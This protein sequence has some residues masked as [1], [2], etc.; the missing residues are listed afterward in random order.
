MRVNN[1]TLPEEFVEC[2]NSGKLQRTRGSWKLRKERDGYSNHLE[3]ELA[4]IFATVEELNAHTS[5]LRDDFQPD[6]FYGA[7]EKASGAPGAIP[8]ILDFSKIVCFGISGDGAPF[9]FDFRDDAERPSVI[10][11]DDNYWRR[12][13][14]DFRSFLKL[15]NFD[16]LERNLEIR[17]R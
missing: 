6:G 4:Q 12:V 3:T 2:T 15:F 5:A 7:S 17:F 1:F 8:N 11:W 14:P 9:C 10:W 13:S 16:E